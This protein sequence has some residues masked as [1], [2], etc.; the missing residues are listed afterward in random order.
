MPIQDQYHPLKTF[1]TNI[2]KN[3]SEW[4]VKKK[5][6]CNPCTRINCNCPNRS[7]QKKGTTNR[8]YNDAKFHE[9]RLS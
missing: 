8:S 2:K 9:Q 5:Q 4:Q 1:Q 6:L 3:K 7:L